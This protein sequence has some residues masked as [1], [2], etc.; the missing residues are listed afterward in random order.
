MVDEVVEDIEGEKIR[1]CYFIKEEN[2]IWTTTYVEMKYL[3]K[4]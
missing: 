1:K 4:E 3:D 2:G